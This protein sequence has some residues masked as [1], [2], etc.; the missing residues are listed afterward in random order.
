MFRKNETLL[1]LVNFTKFLVL[2]LLLFLA[3]TTSV[4]AVNIPA[5][6]GALP[7]P[8]ERRRLAVVE[9]TPLVANGKTRGTV[10][11]YDDPSTAR[12]EDYLEIY[13]HAGD[14]VAVAWFD[15]FGIQRVA[16][17]RAFI[18]GKAQAEGFFIALVDGDFV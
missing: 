13:N 15:R 11:V 1:A 9:S 18:D 10:V 12:R 5:G 7:S 4:A 17:D 6:D 2:A 3:G 16:V 8:T 14:L